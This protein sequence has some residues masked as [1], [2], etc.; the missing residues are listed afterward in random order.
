[1]TR[2]RVAG[3]TLSLDGY[4]AGPDQDINNPLGIGGMELHQWLVATRTFQRTLFG[5]DGGTTGVDDDF[6][7]RS[8][9]NVGA[10]ILGRNMFG[11]IR[12]DWPDDNWKGWW[13]D[14][15]PYHVPVFVLTHH[16]RAPIEMAGGTTFHFITG[17]FREALDR[18]REAADGKDV[19]IGG[20][21]STIRQYLRE[22]LIDELHIA[23]SPVLLGRG[24]PLF[25]GI[26][27]RALGYACVESVASE[28]ATHV[29]LRRPSPTNT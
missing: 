13:G 25:E 9:R 19:R 8:F 27:L 21:P 26:D 3:F 29:V 17:G 1:M 16:A 15:P 28:K 18:A 22:G 6:A 14:N 24:E 12:G 23:I 10:W 20:G 5:K 4:G 11:P 7:A 2:V